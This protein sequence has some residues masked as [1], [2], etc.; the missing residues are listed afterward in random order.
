[1]Q[2]GAGIIGGEAVDRMQIQRKSLILLVL[3]WIS[4][5]GVEEGKWFHC[6]AD[7][8]INEMFVYERINRWGLR[9]QKFTRELKRSWERS[10]WINSSF[11]AE[12][13]LHSTDVFCRNKPCSPCSSTQKCNESFLFPIATFSDE[14]SYRLWIKD[15]DFLKYVLEVINVILSEKQSH[16]KITKSFFHLSNIRKIT[17]LTC[18]LNSFTEI[19]FSPHK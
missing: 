19:E 10:H 6:Q 7:Y 15:R 5:W 3:K 12:R 17:I 16:L 18:Y 13:T 1:M 9:A 2:Q 14:Q 4:F 11:F 8:P